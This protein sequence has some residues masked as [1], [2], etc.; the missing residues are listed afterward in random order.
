VFELRQRAAGNGDSGYE[1]FI[2]L[3]TAGL[4]GT[5]EIGS[6]QWLKIVCIDQA[7]FG[8][9]ACT[10]RASDCDAVVGLTSGDRAGSAGVRVRFQRA[11]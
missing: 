6:I 9:S 8:D 1:F 7:V 2:F 11:G 10:I 5:W 3:L 4:G